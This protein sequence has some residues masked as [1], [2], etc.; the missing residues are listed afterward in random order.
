MYDVDIFFS[1]CGRWIA[2]LLSGGFGSDFRW[3][4]GGDMNGVLLF[5][6]FFVNLKK[7]NL[8][9]TTNRVT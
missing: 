8:E 5:Y 1:A 7:R 9:A 6:F 2:K 4:M 3:F